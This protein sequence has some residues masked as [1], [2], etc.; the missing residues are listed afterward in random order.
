MGHRFPGALPGLALAGGLAC[1]PGAPAP[2]LLLVVVDTLRADHCSAYGYARD[3]T[4]ALR[5]LA[6]Q[7]VRVETAYSPLPATGP[8]HASLFTGL[9]PL[10][11][12]VVKN[13][14]ALAPSLPTLAERLRERGYRTGAVVSSFALAAKFGYARGF[15]E[16]QDDFD[17]QRSTLGF[18]EWEGHAV[19]EGFDRRARPTT[20]RALR[21]L[22]AAAD[23]P[24]PF[25]LFVHYFDPHDPYL[26][27]ARFRRWQ[28]ETP[29]GRAIAAY[30]GEVAY[31]DH[32]LG[33]LLAALEGRGLARDTL[34]VVTGDH[35]EGL[36]DH[37]Y[38][39]HDIQL[40]EE[41]LRVPLVL[42][43]PGRLPAGALLHVPVSLVDLSPALLALLSGTSAEATGRSAALLAALLDP[44]AARPAEPTPIFFQ[45][46]PFAPGRVGAFQVA[47][48][49]FGLR[50][51]RWKYIEAPEESRRE[52]FDLLRDPGERQNLSAQQGA[53]A[54]E[55]SARIARWRERTARAAPAGAVDAADRERLRAMGYAE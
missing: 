5:A 37:G 40:K 17:P 26:P 52:L 14:L 44:D 12:G 32:E 1:G 16:Y 15:D 10:A 30:D 42:R 51:G 45:R 54:D 24:R 4:P 22:E 53:R 29:R 55:L 6:G 39:F 9:P 27:P 50:L 35:G 34:V 18:R 19:P 48:D 20:R 28:G 25:F 33:R 8:T 11:H 2:N 21:W 46:R 41:A 36:L 7:G 31:A 38:M 23:D 49:A 13:G 3:T 43:L 47:G